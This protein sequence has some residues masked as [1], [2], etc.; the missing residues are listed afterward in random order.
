MANKLEERN[1]VTFD[2]IVIDVDQIEGMA[3]GVSDENE[4]IATIMCESGNSIVVSGSTLEKLAHWWAELKLATVV[5]L[6]PELNM[7]KEDALAAVDQLNA[8]RA[9]PQVEPRSA[10]PPSSPS[11]PSEIVPISPPPIKLPTN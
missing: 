11:P 7:A 3:Y 6:P 2:N 5:V 10:Q 1:F 4:E 8:A 9:T